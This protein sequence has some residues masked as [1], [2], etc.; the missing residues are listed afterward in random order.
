MEATVVSVGK[1]VLNGALNYA[2]SM[3]AEEIA[4]QLGVQR[5][6]TFVADEMEMMQSFLMTADD[7]QDEHKVLKTWVKQVRDLAYDV[8]DN[9]Q[10]FALHSDKKPSRWCVLRTLWERRG[11]AKGVKELKA[12]VEDVS[13]RNLRY[14]LIKDASSSKTAAAV[15]QVATAD[16]TVFGFG[17]TKEAMVNLADLVSSKEV[18]LRV[19]S[20]WGTGGD[21]GKTS[22]I[23]KVYDDE[24]V[25][26]RFGCRAWVRLM[27]PFNPREF[28]KSLVRQFYE[29][30][31]DKIAKG[32]EGETV[33]A[34][35]L[36][37]IEKM[38]QMD[39]VLSKFH[40]LVNGNRYLVVIDDLSTIVDWDCI[41]TYFPNRKNGSRIV[42]SAQQAE[43][44]SLC[45]EQ[46]Y[47]MSELKWVSADQTLYLFYKKVEPVE[48]SVGT[49]SG[50]NAPPG[51]NEIA[52][53]ASSP[54]NL[55][56]SPR[57]P[58]LL[59]NEDE[60]GSGRATKASAFEEA[61]LIGRA[62]EK[63][64]V[65]KMISTA[66]QRS[67]ISVWGMGGI[68]KTTLVKG[69]YQ[70]PELAGLFRKH[71]WVTV[72]HPF[73]LEV[74]LRGLA[75]RLQENEQSVS[76]GE[77]KRPDITRMAGRY[78]KN[79][80]TMAYEDLKRELAGLLQEPECLIV[81]DD[82]SSTLEWDAIKRYMGQ[83]R[84]IIVTTRERSVAK[85]CSSLES[86]IYQLHAM[87]EEDDF[88]LFK[89]KVLKKD[90]YID[91]RSDLEEQAKLILKKCHGLP[92]AI[93]T[94]GG[95]LSDKPRTALE[96]KKLNDHISAELEINTELQMIKTILMK[97][98][99]GLPYHLKSSFLYM[100]IFPEDH[101]IRRKRLVRRWIAEGYSSEMR[102]MSAEE[103]G[104]KH[105]AELYDRSMILPTNRVT[106]ST[107]EIDS[108]Q[109]HDLIRDISISKSMEENLV[110]ILE[111]GCSSKVQGTIR[112]LS[113]SS[114]WAR[115][116]DVYESTLDF[117]HIRSL[118]VFGEWRSF[119]IS[120]KMKLL[121]VLD[122]EDTSGLR[123]HD[124][125]HIGK[126][127][128]LR[129]LSLRGCRGVT[130]LPECF[131]N[132]RHLQT[133]DVR[134]TFIMTLPKTIVNLERLQYLRVGFVR[135]DVPK[136]DIYEEFVDKILQQISGRGACRNWCCFY[137]CSLL[138]LCGYLCRPKLL[139]A[140]MNRHDISKF[141]SFFLT[142]G[143]MHHT[144]QGVRVT[145]GIGDLKALR[146]L[147]VVNVAW[148]RHA[149]KVLKRLSHLR[150]LT[151]TGVYDQNSKDFW[152]AIAP[153]NRLRSLSVQ[154]LFESIGMPIIDGCLGENPYMD[155]A[156]ND[157]PAAA[158]APDTVNGVLPSSGGT[159][160][161]KHGQSL[162]GEVLFPPKDLESLKVE[163]R[164][165]KIPQWI[166]QL[167]N[168]SKLQLCYTRLK[169]DAIQVIGRLPN[170][171]ILRLRSLS[172]LGKE[173]HFLHSSFPSLVVLELSDLPQVQVVYFEERTMPRLEVLQVFSCLSNGVLSGLRLLT[174]LKEVSLTRVHYSSIMRVQNQLKDCP[175]PVN[176]RVN[177]GER[178]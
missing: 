106:H 98:Y 138:D 85:H 23:R 36:V 4:L 130:Q 45:T 29:N 107:G 169:L 92:L 115:E 175:K 143:W 141:C 174:S 65:I 68:G 131:G 17:I 14:R 89:K 51:Q 7:E 148:G 112:H 70:S 108:C 79:V 52:P 69:V 48:T 31:P 73:S 67:V 124:L 24:S 159:S 105:F 11:I 78:G 15:E 28:V 9:L 120:D 58:E 88:K 54:R 27:R 164:L 3:L 84:R 178:S 161:S 5:D 82:V 6:V 110:Y 75:E 80:A 41:K 170:L 39:L 152:S 10:D 156:T 173:L 77:K 64:E 113:V 87:G 18:D 74:F 149:M 56:K 172:F 119:L 76:S 1:S 72:K 83:T 47:Q 111:E 153:H 12:R 123:D 21:L 63:A 16:A 34:T 86:D 50:S 46:P 66:E 158:E 150:K 96:W 171:S 42:V 118:T 44:A 144:L 160:Q 8:E 104:D 146:T 167:Q 60:L 135:Q 166:H 154:R 13:S 53:V 22:E 103:V 35:A 19:I 116:K 109:L 151:V 81:L 100:S 136:D 147:S 133:L 55:S 59:N 94:I 142:A 26:K 38:E 62:E 165:V 43:V 2:K 129:Y 37:K 139:H 132:L 97:S 122:L 137:S 95:F 177:F 20:L 93:C 101:K 91:L 127:R 163:G 140:G 176:L 99:N 90:E 71:A 121:R 57:T 128:H 168:L 33:G 32:H 49:S 162:A 114:N 30:S 126:L 40:E 102:H 25:K 157:G 61:L 125:A 117:G 134:D 145:K 155:G